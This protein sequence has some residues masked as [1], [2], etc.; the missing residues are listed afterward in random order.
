MLSDDNLLHFIHTH[1]HTHTHTYISIEQLCGTIQ[2]QCRLSNKDTLT[3]LQCMHLVPSAL[4]LL[5]A[6]TRSMSRYAL[7]LVASTFVW[8]VRYLHG[9]YRFIII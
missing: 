7:V 8:A 2:L 3:H 9:R 5:R 4:Y 6:S 1:T